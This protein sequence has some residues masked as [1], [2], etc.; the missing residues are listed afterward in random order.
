LI[1]H[2]H[3]VSWDIPYPANYGGVIDVYWTLF[4]LHKAGVQ[5]T[6]HC[7]QYGA[8]GPQHQLETLCR[9]VHYYR[10]ETGLKGLSLSLPYI[11]SSRQDTQLVFN[12][13]VDSDPIL[14]E[15]IHTTFLLNSPELANR[16]KLVRP[17]N[18]EHEYY[19]QLATNSPWSLAKI[20][21]GLES[22]LLRHY[23]KRLKSAQAFVTVAKQDTAFFEL[24]YPNAAHCYIPSFQSNQN[25]CSVVGK[26]KY[27]LYHGNLSVTENIRS[28]K[29]L[30][31]EVFAG[32]SHRLIIAGKDPTTEV[33]A[34]QTDFIQVIANPDDAALHQL[35]QEAHVNVLPSFQTSGLK[36][37]LLHALYV[38]RFCLVNE[39][40][41]V[42]T[43]LDATVVVAN[44]AVSMRN[45]IS[46]LS[47]A[48][49]TEHDAALRKETL[50]PYDVVKNA[51]RLIEFIG[52]L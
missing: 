2:L 47:A 41:L 34:M 11:V 30:V 38:G 32:T 27:H 7:F 36:L 8:R 10:R 23:E 15:G 16:I 12:L 18:I 13:T 9:K 4:H 48:S 20:Y 39:D 22:M 49:F 42:G 14:F 17:Q 24:K 33:L 40:M 43:G 37:K 5:I 19:A 21:Y 1:K 50:R 44:D 29:F 51:L 52:S 6:L 46:Q 3:I 25:V 28:V 45:A 31:D 35:I 26:G